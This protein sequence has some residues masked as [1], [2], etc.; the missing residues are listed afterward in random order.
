MLNENDF[1]ISIFKPPDE[2]G[3][4][5]ELAFAEWDWNDIIHNG[6]DIQNKDIILY[7]PN[8]TIEMGTMTISFR[9]IDFL[10][11]NMA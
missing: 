4:S 8:Q 7:D 2:S 3:I 5:N 6:Q 1:Q 9:G 11:K 10:K